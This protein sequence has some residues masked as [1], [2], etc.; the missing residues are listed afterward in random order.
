MLRLAPDILHLLGLLHGRKP[1]QGQQLRGLRGPHLRLHLH[2]PQLRVGRTEG[3]VQ[4][5]RG[6]MQHL[7]QDSQVFGKQGPGTDSINSF[8]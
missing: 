6:Q 3:G 2:H 4:D 1:E 8:S 7:G 5:V